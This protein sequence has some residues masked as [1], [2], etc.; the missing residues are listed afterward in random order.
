MLPWERRE[1]PP[2]Q[3]VWCQQD[4]TEVARQFQE[5]HRLWLVGTISGGYWWVPNVSWIQ[6]VCMRV[7]SLHS[8]FYPP[9][10]STPR[11]T[12]PPSPFPPRCASVLN[13]GVYMG[14]EGSA[15]LN[16]FPTPD[17]SVPAV[18]K[19]VPNH[20]VMWQWL[21]GVACVR[22]RVAST[23]SIHQSFEKS[24]SLCFIWDHG[25]LFLR[26]LRNIQPHPL[27]VKGGFAT[28]QRGMFPAFSRHHCPG[29]WA[30][31]VKTAIKRT[32]ICFIPKRTYTREKNVPTLII[33]CFRFITTRGRWFTRFSDLKLSCGA[34]NALFVGP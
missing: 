4:R 33:R 15:V 29:I 1:Y 13:A 5:R 25:P 28:V 11:A 24:Y 12:Y 9:P 21:Q 8:W 14:Q 18:N 19:P 7:R 34:F 16:N 3:H 26:V 10:P 2:C 17:M 23:P 27:I 30:F 22:A 32:F 6:H 31:H 20:Y